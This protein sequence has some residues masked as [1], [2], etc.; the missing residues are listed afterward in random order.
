MYCVDI[1]N[2]KEI[3]EK[4]DSSC[5]ILVRNKDI[6]IWQ[7][8]FYESC[9]PR[10]CVYVFLPNDYGHLYEFEQCLPYNEK[11]WNLVLTS[12]NYK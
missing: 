7:I 6:E 4:L 9:E 10:E 8:G 5:R 12:E 11:T 1:N 2:E 3:E